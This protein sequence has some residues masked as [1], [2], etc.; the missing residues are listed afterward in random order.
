MIMFAI[1]AQHPERPDQSAF[2]QFFKRKEGSSPS[3]FRYRYR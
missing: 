2:G 1:F 3:E